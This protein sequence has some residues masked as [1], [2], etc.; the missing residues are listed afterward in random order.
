M[1]VA[2]VALITWSSLAYL[3]YIATGFTFWG[4]LRNHGPTTLLM[5]ILLAAGFVVLARL[6]R[7]TQTAKQVRAFA[8]G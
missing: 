7:E 1:P 2:S 4:P 6:L 3:A 8:S 5:L